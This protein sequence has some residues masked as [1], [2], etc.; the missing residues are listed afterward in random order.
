MRGWQVLAMT[1]LAAVLVLW[2]TLLQSQPV[3]DRI[4]DELELVA[5]DGG[6]DVHVSLTIPVRY[7]S[8]FPYEA[9]DELRIRIKAFDVRGGDRD[10]LFKRESL[11]PSGDDFPAL[12]E[13]VYEGDI[14]GGRYLT[15]LFSQC[16]RFEVSQ[17]RDSRSIMVRVAR[18]PSPGHDSDPAVE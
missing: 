7:I 1:L 11:V 8:H 14:D 17:G 10:A 4:L 18:S 3:R 2:Q 12:K 16:V 5:S 6:V 9:G 13:V 15:L